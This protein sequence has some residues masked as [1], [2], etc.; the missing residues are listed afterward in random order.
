MAEASSIYFPFQL[1]SNWATW[2]IEAAR[3]ALFLGSSSFRM[4]VAAGVPN[5]GSFNW[6]VPETFHVLHDWHDTALLRVGCSCAQSAECAH[7]VQAFHVTRDTHTVRLADEEGAAYWPGQV[8]FLGD[9]NISLGDAQSSL[10]GVKSSLGDAKSSL[11]DAE[12]FLGDAKS[13]LG[14]AES[15]L[16]D[17]ESFLGDAKSSLG[18]A[19]SSLGDAKSSLGDAKSFAG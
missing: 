9:A 7:D 8:S 16:G 12:S 2:L 17:A 19:K 18:D 14:D 11:G 6:T 15:S 13:S 4:R 3:W 5:S 1:D 10:G